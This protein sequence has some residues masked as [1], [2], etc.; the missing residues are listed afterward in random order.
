MLCLLSDPE[1]AKKM[2]AAGHKRIAEHFSAAKQAQEHIALY[3]QQWE[4]TL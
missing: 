2:G 4:L 3:L 1:Q